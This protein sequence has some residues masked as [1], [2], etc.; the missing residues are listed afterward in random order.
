LNGTI[1]ALKYLA[2]EQDSAA[3]KKKIQEV[4]PEYKP[5]AA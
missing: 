3:I 1:D 2:Y 4:V 5:A